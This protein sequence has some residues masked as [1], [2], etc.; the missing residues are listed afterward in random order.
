MRSE[1]STPPATPAP[2]S[3]AGAVSPLLV[4][5]SGALALAR[6]LWE[7][8]AIQTLFALWIGR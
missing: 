3:T 7:G 2:A 5:D 1:P 8:P 4:G 6:P